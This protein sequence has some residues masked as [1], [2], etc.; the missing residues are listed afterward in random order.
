MQRGDDRDRAE[1][2]LLQR[3]MPH[4]RVQQALGGVAL[5]QLRE[6]EA[7]AEVLSGAVEYGSPY[8]G[9]RQFLFEQLAQTE[10]EAVAERVAL[11]R[12]VQPDHGDR[13]LDLQ[14]DVFVGHGVIAG[15]RGLW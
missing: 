12:T 6:V 2:H 10:N 4:P 8:P 13:T 7:G 5:L 11:G 1:L 9:C 3:G 15:V 14:E